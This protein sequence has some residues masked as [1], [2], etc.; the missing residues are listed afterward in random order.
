MNISRNFKIPTDSLNHIKNAPRRSILGIAL[1]L[2]SGLL[3]GVILHQNDQTISVMQLNRSLAIGEK[4]TPD[5]YHLISV[6]ATFSNVPWLR[7]VDDSELVAR[8]SLSDGVL[9]TEFD[10]STNGVATRDICVHVDS[11]PAGVAVGDSVD[12]WHHGESYP[13]E[14]V[15]EAAVVADI[16]EADSSTGFNVTLRISGEE[17]ASGLSASNSIALVGR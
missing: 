10:F 5:A 3:G 8:H 14:R 4:L 15:I 13:A 2:L 17:V 7:R 6:P 12:V 9:L 1:I 16:R 11:I